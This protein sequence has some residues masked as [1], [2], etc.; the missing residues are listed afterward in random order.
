MVSRARRARQLKPT[1]KNIAIFVHAPLLLPKLLQLCPCRP[2]HYNFNGGWLASF[3][4]GGLDPGTVKRTIGC[5]SQAI[6]ALR[7][8]FDQRQ[9]PLPF[10]RAGHLP[11]Q[12]GDGIVVSMDDLYVM[13]LKQLK[14][15]GVWTAA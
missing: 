1:R 4:S 5:G 3:T 13:W 8:L 2:G 9:L 12:L 7:L 11:T 15:R 6:L 14:A 10:A